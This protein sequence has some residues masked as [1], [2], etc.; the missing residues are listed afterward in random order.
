MTGTHPEITRYFMTIRKPPAD[1]AGRLA[2][3][4]SEIFALDMANGAYPDLAEQ[5]IRLTA[6]TRTRLAIVFTGLRP[7]EKL[8][9]SCSTSRRAIRR[10]RTQD[11]AGASARAAAR[12]D[13]SALHAARQAMHRFDE[14]ALLQMLRDLVPEFSSTTQSTESLSR[15]SPP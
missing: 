9:R 8:L 2:G 10:P 7:G 12:I 13:R 3:A 11:R 6:S 1:P 4:V 5:M 14:V 15:I